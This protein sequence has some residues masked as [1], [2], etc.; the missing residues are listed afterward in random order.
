MLFSARQACQV[1]VQTI[2]KGPF[3]RPSHE[4]PSGVSSKCCPVRTRSH[5]NTVGLSSDVFQRVAAVE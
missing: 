2:F 1:L 5:G 4:R 3:R